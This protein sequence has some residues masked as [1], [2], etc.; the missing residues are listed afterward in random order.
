[1]RRGLLVCGTER[2]AFASLDE[3]DS[4]QPLQLNLPTTSVR[5]FVFTDTDLVV[6]THGRGI[7]VIDQIAPLRQLSDAVLAST[8]HLFKPMDATAY[9]QGG[10]NGTP[11]QKDE[12]HAENPPAGVAIDYWLARDASGPVTVEILDAA[13]K[14]VGVFSSDPAK[15]PKARARRGGATGGLP[16]VSPLWIPAPFAMGTSAGLHRVVWDPYLPPTRGGDGDGVA[17]GQFRT[18]SFTAR[19][20]VGGETRS[21]QFVVHPAA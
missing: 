5:D 14:S 18:G 7:W 2:G 9:I 1:M 11:L 3:G 12:P 20:T 16:S 10:D 17:A 13:G 21:Q 4:W 6:G 8:V 15:Q 19:L